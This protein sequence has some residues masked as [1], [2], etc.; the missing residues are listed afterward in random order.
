MGKTRCAIAVGILGFGLL[1]TGP[2]DAGERR[3]EHLYMQVTAGAAAVD[4]LTFEDD[5]NSLDLTTGDGV[6]GFNSPWANIELGYALYNRFR[7]GVHLGYARSDVEQ[8][9][10]SGGPV[11]V[12]GRTQLI[13]FGLN[14]YYDV[15]TGSAL[16]PYLGLGVGGLHASTQY[17]SAALLGGERDVDGTGF[18]AQALAGLSLPVS[19]KIDFLFGY[20]YVY[21][22]SITA[23]N[24]DLALDGELEVMGHVA[25][26]GLRFV[27]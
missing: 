1:G 13:S 10:L 3:G 22:P 6:A 21:A 17:E 9:E 14:G 27:P 19:D 25:E 24:Q 23:E 26:I 2:A 18:A 12:D 15:D 11:D 7:V 5:T 4:D 16:T 8:L 20:R